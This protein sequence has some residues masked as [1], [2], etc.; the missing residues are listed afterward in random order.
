M[1]DYEWYITP[2]E[3]ERAAANG[4]TSRTLEKR[5]R[6]RGWAKERAIN[7]PVQ[8]KTNL[9]KWRRIAEQNGI[10]SN[11]FYKR[12]RVSGW[13]PERA[14]TEPLIDK[15][16]RLC[17]QNKDRRTYPLEMIAIAESNGISYDL[18][19]ERVN[20]YGWSF[21]RAAT[22]PKIPASVSGRRGKES[23]M[24]RVGNIYLLRYLK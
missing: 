10:P 14:A 6:D 1:Q 9:L 18:F 11:A 17:Q 3:Y 19:K 20:K 5:I 4:I 22:E 24:K 7:E 13:E 12:V 23:L 16:D 21:D 15:V 8:K 2:E